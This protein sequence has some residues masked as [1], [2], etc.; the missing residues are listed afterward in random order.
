MGN[1]EFDK[2]K[3]SSVR[4]EVTQRDQFNNDD[5]SLAEALVRE[6]IQNS[7]DAPAGDGPVKVRFNIKTV[8]GSDAKTLSSQLVP[9]LPHLA[10]CSVEGAPLSASS[11][12]LIAIEDF[13]TKGLTGSFDD[14]DGGN[15]DRF[16]RTVGDSGKTGKEGGRWGLGKLVYSSASKIKVFFGLTITKDN[17]VASMM[18]QVV[19]K[20]HRLKDTFHPSH[21]FYFNGSSQPLGLQKPIQDKDEIALLC[22]LAGLSRTDQT[23]L[24]LVIPYLVEGINEAS[25]ISGVVSNYYFPILAGRLIVE[26]GDVVIS[27][28]TFL[29]VAEVQ[30]AARNIPFGFVKEISDTVDIVPDVIAAKAIGD[31]DLDGDSFTPGQVAMMKDRFASGELVRARVPVTLK[32]KDSAN[33]NSFVDLYLRTLPESEKPFALIARGPIT[34]PGERRHFGAASAYGALIANDEGI[35]SFLGDAENPA[36]TAWNPRAEKLG[37]GW[38]SP[39]STLASIRHSL[40]QLYALVSDQ[41]ESEDSEALVD[42]FSIMEKG[43]ASKGKRKKASRQVVNVPAREVAIRIKERR[44]GF[45]I[46]AGPAAAKWTFPHSIRVK[47]AYDMIG[48]NPFKRHSPFDFDFEKGREIKIGLVNATVEPMK[49][50]VLKVIAQA[51]DFQVEFDGFD[52]RRDI[53]V[54]ASAR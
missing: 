42:F 44:G 7:S 43:P 6:A 26:V 10:A 18:G 8:S 38:R 22:D 24:S 53:V 40:R 19:L 20:N 34:L 35:A 23:G 48:A 14:V 4:I 45:Q 28:E 49:P 37:P 29:E 17:P 41:I 32:P 39:Q 2:V 5:V 51:P 1:W 13:N 31:T 36:H 3:P 15:F 25:L 9:L 12:Q 46:V 27:K 52:E 21:G 11:F 54:D 33:Y 47:V 30:P 16:W 50:N